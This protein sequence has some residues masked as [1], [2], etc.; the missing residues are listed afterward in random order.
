[1]DD[2]H[3]ES[4]ELL[5]TSCGNSFFHFLADK[6]EVGH[7]TKPRPD[8]TAK[9]SY[10]KI[11]SKIK[12]AIPL[13]C[14]RR[15][16]GF[17]LLYTNERSGC[18]ELKVGMSRKTLVNTFASRAP[19]RSDDVAAV[20]KI[21]DSDNT[22]L[23]KEVTRGTLQFCFGLDKSGTRLK[24]VEGLPW[25]RDLILQ[26]Y[27]PC[28]GP[29][30]TLY[31]VV[32]R[33]STA[34]SAQVPSKVWKLSSLVPSKDQ[35]LVDVHTS[36]KCGVQDVSG[37]KFV[38]EA[39]SIASC[40]AASAGRLASKGS[41]RIKVVE[42][43]VDFILT[44]CHQ[45]HVIQTKAFKCVALKAPSSFPSKRM[46]PIA[47]KCCGD[48]CGSL[49]SRENPLRGEGKVNRFS[50]AN[51]RKV[52][53]VKPF[54]QNKEWGEKGSS[55]GTKK[56]RED[57][58]GGLTLCNQLEEQNQLLFKIPYKLILYDRSN[59]YLES[60]RMV[61]WMF[62][63]EVRGE[64]E[65]RGVFMDQGIH[66]EWEVFDEMESMLIEDAF[67]KGCKFFRLREAVSVSFAEEK[68]ECEHS[69]SYSRYDI[70]RH[71]PFVTQ[72][73]VVDRANSQ[74]SVQGAGTTGFAF[75][76]N[77]AVEQ[78]VSSPNHAKKKLYD[79]VSVCRDCYRVYLC[80]EHMKLQGMVR[81]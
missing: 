5:S 80:K 42:M 18:L 62:R 56:H 30:S 66:A 48:Y 36:K 43:V 60:D 37:R 57:F 70:K 24:K 54:A 41:S 11:Q 3:R 64:G 32:W 9:G 52:L 47:S 28:K 15:N 50:E 65:E 7:A 68:M 20:M 27:L 40:F 45:W 25:G 35:P 21:Q 31:R 73:Y 39:V 78:A 38:E 71:P 13:T 6:L 58:S 59:A 2:D 81:E 75:D 74:R 67:Q 26:Q 61:K 22:S 55:L 77:Q 4:C 29:T 34:L 17:S 79:M 1:M 12:L 51:G 8:G 63:R 69:H 19:P 72:Q 46:G 16:G 14:L 33:S 44:E 76:P 49:S 23:C 53:T 10:R